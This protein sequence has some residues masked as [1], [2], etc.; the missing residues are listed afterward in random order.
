MTEIRIIVTDESDIAEAAR[1]A[2]QMAERMGFDRVQTCYVATAAS[3]LAA[4]LFVH[5]GG[6]IFEAH[7]VAAGSALEISTTD[8]G[9]GIPDIGLALQEGY[10]TAGGLG[11]GLPGVKRLMDDLEIA[12]CPG[13]GTV[14]RARKWR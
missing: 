14:V 13:G 9:P 5:A 10:S 6:G 1:R 7:P 3:E 12:S 11:C 4:N 8:Q 2:R